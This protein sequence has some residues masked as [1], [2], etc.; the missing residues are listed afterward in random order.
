MK[1]LLIFTDLDGTLLDHDNYD[2]SPAK[3]ALKRLAEMNLPLIFNSSKTIE[4]MKPLAAELNSHHPI[5]A[6]NGNMVITEPNYFPSLEAT[7]ICFGC[8]YPQIISALNN[9]RNTFNFRF[10]GFNDM[11]I[12]ALMAHTGLDK[13]SARRAHARLFSEPLLWQQDEAALERFIKELRHYDLALTRGGRFY[14]VMRPVDKSQ[15]MRWLL[16]QYQKLE[17]QTQWITVALGDSHNDLEMLQQADIAVLITNPS[18]SAPDVAHIN[19]LIHPASPGP[20]GW[21]EA[22]NLIIDQNIED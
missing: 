9:L 21:N 8:D 13:E 3:P 20:A 16:Q 7:T 19:H 15:S 5:I 22:I 6:E 12:E 14:H 11:S 17:P 10:C 18:S 2:W 1:K 4:E